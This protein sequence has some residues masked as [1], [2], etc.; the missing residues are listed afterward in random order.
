MKENSFLI[1]QFYWHCW[2]VCHSLCEFNV[3]RIFQQI[4]RAFVIVYDGI[5]FILFIQ[6]KF[7][8]N[9]NENPNWLT[10]KRQISFS[11]NSFIQ[12]MYDGTVNAIELEERA[13]WIWRIYIEQNLINNNWKGCLGKKNVS[14][15]FLFPLLSPFWQSKPTNFSTEYEKDGISKWKKENF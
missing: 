1:F 7:V 3:D 13:E 8:Y 5:S 15:K 14:S 10:F 2:S 6:L 12:F 9:I 11:F 4:K